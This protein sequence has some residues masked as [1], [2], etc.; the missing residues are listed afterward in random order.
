MKISP[1]LALEGK[2]FKEELPDAP[3][4]FEIFA[5]H[6]RFSDPS[7]DTFLGQKPVKATFDDE[8]RCCGGASSGDRKWT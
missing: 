2:R 3:A 7:D 1:D 6:G 4:Q 8:R 5:L